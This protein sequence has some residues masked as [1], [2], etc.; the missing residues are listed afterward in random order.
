MFEKYGLKNMRVILVQGGCNKVQAAARAS[1]GRP[2]YEL[3]PNCRKPQC[4][5]GL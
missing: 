5:A 1:S 3:L 4:F 2:A